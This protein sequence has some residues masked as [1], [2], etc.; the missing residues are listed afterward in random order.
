MSPVPTMIPPA[1]IKEL[2]ARKPFQPSVFLY[3][4]A[5]WISPHGMRHSFASICVSKEIDIYRIATLPGDDVR[6][7][8]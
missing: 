8:L 7:A 2:L 4:T 6:V 1:R 5:Q 3:R